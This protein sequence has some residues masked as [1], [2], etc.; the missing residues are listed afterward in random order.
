MA[1]PQQKP[2]LFDIPLSDAERGFLRSLRLVGGWVPL[3]TAEG[4]RLAERCKRTGYIEI[5][6]R[7]AKPFARLTGLGQAYL[8]RLTT[9]E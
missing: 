1:A 6:R 9:V 5:A 4:R 7:N 3:N 8:K 2:A